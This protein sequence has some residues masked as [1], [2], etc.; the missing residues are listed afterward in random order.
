MAYQNPGLQHQ[1]QQNLTS[2]QSET[3]SGMEGNL[4]GSTGESGHT[5][6]VLPEEPA[7]D[8]LQPFGELWNYLLYVSNC[9]EEGKILKEEKTNKNE[10]ENIDS[11]SNKM[12]ENEIDIDSC[13]AARI[14]SS[15][16]I[17]DDDGESTSNGSSKFKGKDK[18]KDREHLPN[19]LEPSDSK[20]H[21][22]RIPINTDK[23]V[24]HNTASSVPSSGGSSAE[25]SQKSSS[26][27]VFNE[28]ENGNGNGNMT[29]PSY[30][31]ES[32][33]E[34]VP[35]PQAVTI[36]AIMTS[37]GQ[38]VCRQLPATTIA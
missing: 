27:S 13:E 36:A 10:N 28:H 26:C 34:V 22:Y 15:N 33:V 25:H 20:N 19:D 18:D 14:Y 4:A 29:D 23:A 2:Y 24:I 11:M 6:E 31:S 37:R 3:T 5:V 30:I 38:Y 16:N 21:A 7:D 17:D 35:P 9:F 12:D 8:E 32:E 1:Y